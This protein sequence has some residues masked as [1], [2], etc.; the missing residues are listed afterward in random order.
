MRSE[1]SIKHDKEIR[2]LRNQGLLRP[3]GTQTKNYDPYMEAYKTFE[4]SVMPNKYL[5][6][7]LNNA[8]KFSYRPGGSTLI[9]KEKQALDKVLKAC[10]DK[11]DEKC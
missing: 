10:L 7:D 1:A 5:F 4:G 2:K 3:L 11:N 8:I 9:S 6:W